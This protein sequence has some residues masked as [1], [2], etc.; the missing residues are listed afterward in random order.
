MTFWMLAVTGW[1]LCGIL[2]LC[3]LCWLEGEMTLNDLI[4]FVPFGAFGL[5]VV[6]LIFTAGSLME[7]LKRADT[8][9]LW[10]KKK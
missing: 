8:I 7:L 10:S 3:F 2:T 9:V 6:L 4:V 5:V 1:L